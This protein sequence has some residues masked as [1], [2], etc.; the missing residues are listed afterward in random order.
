MTHSPKILIIRLSS[1][2]DMLHALPAAHSLRDAFP[3]AQIDWLVESRFA[4]LLGAVEGISRIIPIDTRTVRSN[5]LQRRSWRLLWEPLRRVRGAG[6]DIVIDC[7]GLLKTAWMSVISGAAIRIG[8]SRELVRERPAQ[9]FY[10]RTV[11]KP[12]LPVHVA[13]LNL[14]LAEKAGARLMQLT[15]CLKARDADVDAVTCRLARAQLSRFVVINP[16][17]GWPT[18]R[19]SPGRYGDLAEQIQ[20]ELNLPVVVVTGPGEESM[21]REIAGRC[22][23]RPPVHFDLS[24]LELIPLFERAKLVVSGDTGPLHLAC[25]VGTPVVAIMGPTS[26]IRNGPWSPEDK[27]VAHTLP[28]SFCYGRSCPTMN[29]C[30]DIRVEEVFAAVVSRLERC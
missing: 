10:N 2:G 4:F 25:A 16:G 21:Y 27:T 28:C 17:G 19:W 11:E 18:K 9:W 24:F 13:S 29:E 7:Q 8:F 12:S 30:M 1:L 3:E 14:L 5:M 26:P 15:S 20:T 6:Y 23:G 22:H